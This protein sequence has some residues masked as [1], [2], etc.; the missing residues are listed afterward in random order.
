MESGT[1]DDGTQA[2]G[3]RVLAHP[4][5]TRMVTALQERA[6]GPA[7]LADALDQPSQLVAYHYRVLKA[8]GGPGALR[9]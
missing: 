7:E 2:G 8:A 6:L 3:E 1:K 4:L 5:R 9:R